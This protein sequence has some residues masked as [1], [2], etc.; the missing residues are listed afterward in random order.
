MTD[1]VNPNL[2]SAQRSLEW[3][4][5]VTDERWPAILA[6]A[7]RKPHGTSAEGKQSEFDRLDEEGKL[8]YFTAALT[9]GSDYNRS[10]G[11]ETVS[12]DVAWEA[13][14]HRDGSP[15]AVAAFA[16]E[17]HAPIKPCPNKHYDR[18]T[19]WCLDCGTRVEA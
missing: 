14:L 17:E 7:V 12:H 18:G 16:A 13:A 2:M 19:G 11:L 3:Q 10:I 9:P 6:E 8:I 4:M 1:D 15:E 5:P